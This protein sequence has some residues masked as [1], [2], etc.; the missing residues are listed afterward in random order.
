MNQHKD[1]VDVQN[2]MESSFENF[3]TTGWS[4]RN[5][6]RSKIFISTD[7]PMH[8]LI[9]II[10]RSVW[11]EQ[12]QCRADNDDSIPSQKT[13]PEYK[14]WG[15]KRSRRPMSLVLLLVRHSLTN[16]MWKVK[17]SSSHK[18]ERSPLQKSKMSENNNL[19]KPGT[20]S[21]G[22]WQGC[23]KLQKLYA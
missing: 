6:F 19:I 5:L 8:E 14:M 21:F 9:Y 15:K 22:Y 17:Q 12:I 3:W 7:T 23:S 10:R 20:D 16:R 2:T 18:D 11:D 4:E 13:Q 1:N